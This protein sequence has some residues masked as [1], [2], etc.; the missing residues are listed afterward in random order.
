[1]NQ[2]V[3][4]LVPMAVISSLFSAD[5]A[6]H[7]YQIGKVDGR[8]EVYR[9]RELYSNKEKLDRLQRKDLLDTFVTVENFIGLCIGLFSGMFLSIFYLYYNNKIVYMPT[10]ID[11]YKQAQSNVFP[12]LFGMFGGTIAGFGI[13]HLSYRGHYATK[14]EQE[15]KE[16]QSKIESIEKDIKKQEKI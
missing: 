14:R 9:Q 7:D 16:C 6:S 4:K 15:I 12:L 13:A 11:D 5:T 2:K 10:T 3:L 1:M 8:L